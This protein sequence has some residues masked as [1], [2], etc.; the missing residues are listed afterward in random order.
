MLRC[1]S[2]ASSH[3][4]LRGKVSLSRV[5]VLR[6]EWS[7]SFPL[8]LC[9]Q[10]AHLELRYHSVDILTRLTELRC[11][12]ES[13]QLVK[14]QVDSPVLFACLNATR[15][16]ALSMVDSQFMVH[17]H[18]QG[19]HCPH[20]RV[21]RAT[22]ENVLS[23][24]QLNPQLTHLH[25]AVPAYFDQDSLA[26]HALEHAEVNELVDATLGPCLR[27]LDVTSAQ[28]DMSALRVCSGLEDL[29][30]RRVVGISRVLL[31]ELPALQRLCLVD[32]QPEKYPNLPNLKSLRL[33]GAGCLIAQLP[34]GLQEL[35]VVFPEAQ[36]LCSFPDSLVS[37][38]TGTTRL[39]RPIPP[40]NVQELR[41]YHCTH[42]GVL[43]GMFPNLTR[44]VNSDNSGPSH[45]TGLDVVV[46]PSAPGRTL[47]HWF[48]SRQFNDR[49]F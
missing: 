27:V 38:K 35:D 22:R 26:F 3:A 2:P 10:L 7:H 8:H 17:N 36:F 20:L 21:I 30:L 32:C 18:K 41:D 24:L 23:L 4:L 48:Q 40:N 45:V 6:L 25:V 43:L 31:P 46:R 29:S 37:L 16:Y 42:R 49:Q 14:C 9:A 47:A 15:A 33:V 34:A 12:L 13:L 11:R 28:W 44:I 19:V 39:V 1:S 5:S